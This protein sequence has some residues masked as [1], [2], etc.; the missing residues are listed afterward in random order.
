QKERKGK[1]RGNGEG[2]IY[3]RPDGRYC[4]QYKDSEGN[5]KT[6]YAKTEAEAIKRLREKLTRVEKNLP[7]EDSRITVEKFLE[8]WLDD[9][10][11]TIRPKT[12]KNYSDLVRLHITPAIGRV[13]LV[14][15]SKGQVQSMLNGI[16][17]HSTTQETASS[18]PVSPMTVFHVR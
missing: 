5:R 12:F 18:K 11:G 2:T 15:L 16:K 1:A 6:L 7:V 10:K 9:I 13:Q 17:R 4:A 3:Q 8:K 14:K